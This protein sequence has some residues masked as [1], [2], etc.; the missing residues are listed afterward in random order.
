M[1][2]R[3]VASTITDAAGL[4]ACRGA[5]P[6]GKIAKTC[7]TKFQAAFDSTAPASELITFQNISIAIAEYERSQVFV[8]T[9]WRSYIEGDRDAISKAAKRGARLF[10]ASAGESGAG[11]GE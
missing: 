8:N 10:Y 5:D 6:K 3:S 2:N 1:P 9:P 4:G 11:C 7:V